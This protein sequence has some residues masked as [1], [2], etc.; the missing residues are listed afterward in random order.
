MLFQ[1]G[2]RAA[3]EADEFL[4]QITPH[5]PRLT[6]V[7]MRLTHQ[8]S[9][10]Q[11][12]VQ[13]ALTKAWANWHR[14]RPGGSLGAWLA[15]ILINTF[16]SRHRH[17]RVVDVTASRSDIAAHLFDEGRMD[18]CSAPE[19]AWQ[20]EQLSDEVTA[21]LAF[22]STTARSSSWSTSTGSPTARPP[23]SS[24]ARSAPS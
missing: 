21:A 1:S 10:A 20:A 17:Q 3:T 22:P 14:Y 24:P 2:M 13:E 12:L 8:R 9:E 16:I 23:S 19:E 5:I 7:G 18:A 4:R 11:D 6:S 15:R